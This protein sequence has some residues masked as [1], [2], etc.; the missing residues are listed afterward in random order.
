MFMCWKLKVTFLG[1][2]I[3]LHYYNKSPLKK[4]SGTKLMLMVLVEKKSFVDKAEH[5]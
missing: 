1:E 5:K 3:F 4:H 2:M